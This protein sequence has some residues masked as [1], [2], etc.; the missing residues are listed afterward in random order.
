MHT[1]KPEVVHIPEENTL[2]MRVNVERLRM[3]IVLSQPASPPQCDSSPRR[4]PTV[5]TGL[6]ETGTLNVESRSTEREGTF[7]LQASVDG[8]LHVSCTGP[9]QEWILHQV[10]VGVKLE[11]STSEQAAAREEF[12]K[13]SKRRQ[14]QRMTV[15]MYVCI[16]IKLHITAQSGPVIYSFYATAC[17]PPGGYLCMYVW[18]SHIAEYGSTG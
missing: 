7:L 17:N 11:R 8:V 16:F 10:D 12:A 15:C 6:N 5:G 2:K 14:Q 4:F 13:P 18:S 3:E 1:C 9:E